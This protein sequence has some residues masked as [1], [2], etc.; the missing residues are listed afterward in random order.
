MTTQ[1]QFVVKMPSVTGDVDESENRWSW[2]SPLVD[3]VATSDVAADILAFYGFIDAFFSPVLSRGTGACSIEA[4][5]VSGHLNGSPAGPPVYMASWT[6]GPSEVTAGYPNQ[7]AMVCDHHADLS[8]VAEFGPHTRPRARRRGRHYLG[9]MAADTLTFATSGDFAVT[10]A[11]A[12]RTA[13]KTAYEHA[14]ASTHLGP[15]WS[16]WSRVDAAMYP[17][18]GGWIDEVPRTRRTRVIPGT[19]DL[20]P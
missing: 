2:Q 18:I 7:L 4:Y 12:K 6:L 13:V 8:G 19:K 15:G 16:V 14:L 10:W 9:P 3:S 5:D 20:W 1:L 17:I 11:A